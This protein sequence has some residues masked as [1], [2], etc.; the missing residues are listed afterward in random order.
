MP[1]VTFIDHEGR[2][3]LLMDFSGIKDAQRFPALV[4]EAIRLVHETKVRRSVLA[5]LDLT[6]TPVNRPVMASLK[7][8]SQNNGPYIKAVTFVGLGTFWS[9][10][11]S[12]FFRWTKRR[13]HKVM[14]D[15]S[16]ALEWLVRQ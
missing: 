14:H 15:R 7:R 2:Q 13:N 4:D 9:A 1:G 8:M 6:G 10:I 3:I 16:R 12:A 5:L 11:V